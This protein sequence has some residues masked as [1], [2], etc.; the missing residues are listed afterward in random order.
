M[1]TTHHDRSMPRDYF[2]RAAGLGEEALAAI[3][4]TRARAA[5]LFH[6]VAGRT[7]TLARESPWAAA[8]AVFGLGAILGVIALQLFVPRRTVAALPAR[9]H[10]PVKAKRPLPRQ[11]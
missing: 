2:T 6:Q 4:D 9:I 8:G 5:G 11:R 10:R 3:T 1:I 7:E